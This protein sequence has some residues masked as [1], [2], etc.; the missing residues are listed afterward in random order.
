[1]KKTTTTKKKKR[2]T[3]FSTHVSVI[4][5]MTSKEKSGRKLTVSHKSRS[6]SYCNI[7]NSFFS[8]SWL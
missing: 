8:F 6:C 1:M 3:K 5:K 7:E 4:F 2:E